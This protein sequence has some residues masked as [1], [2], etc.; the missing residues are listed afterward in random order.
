MKIGKQQFKALIKECLIEIFSEGLGS[1]LSE[2][3]KHKIPES[4]TANVSF[5]R[6]SRQQKKVSQ[7]NSSAL[8]NA[9]K[10]AAGADD[11]MKDIFADTARNTLPTMLSEG[12]AQQMQQ[13]IDQGVEAQIVAN[14]D[15][16]DIFGDENVDR[17]ASLA[18][19]SKSK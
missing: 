15:P 3:V 5:N 12:R 8:I 11:V 17:W 9:I 2:S 19:N 6:D 7:T 14:N 1:Q 4:N 13:P 16:G 18:F 10:E